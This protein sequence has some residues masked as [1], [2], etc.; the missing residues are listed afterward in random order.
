MKLDISKALRNPEEAFS[1]TH[2]EH[3]DPQDVLGDMVSF[4]PVRMNG[5]YVLLDG[6]LHL[7]G[8]MSTVAH[9]SCARCMEAADYP[10]DLEF[11]EVF[12]RKGEKMEDEEDEL[13]QMDRLAYDGPLLAVDQMALTLAVLELP[14]RFLCRKDCKGLPGITLRNREADADQEE[15]TTQHPFSALQQLLNK[16]Q[17]V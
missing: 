4:D 8:R 2:E 3:I 11:Y 10:I 16:D 15:L 7:Q 6:R 12:T 5:S 9:G 14:M 1:F 13:D 17:E